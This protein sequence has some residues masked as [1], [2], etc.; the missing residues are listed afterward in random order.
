MPQ[1][2]SGVFTIIT[3]CSK[4]EEHVA[5]KI[6]KAFLKIKKIEKRSQRFLKKR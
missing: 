2:K 3:N 1:N 4:S 5:K 6:R